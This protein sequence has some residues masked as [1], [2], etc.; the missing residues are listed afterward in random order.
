MAKRSKKS[1]K[2]SIH[3][4]SK[5]DHDEAGAWLYHEAMVRGIDME[6]M[7]RTQAY[8]IIH[9]LKRGER[10]MDVAKEMKLL[11][12]RIVSPSRKQLREMDDLGL[13]SKHCLS[14]Y[15]ASQVLKAHKEPLKVYGAILRQIDKC[16]SEDDLFIAGKELGIVKGSLRADWYEMLV[17]EGK[18]RRSEIEAKKNGEAF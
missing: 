8:G 11:M 17:E 7:S 14:W 10:P 15:H 2:P 12:F 16:V 18:K 1:S 13:P 9:R 6:W 4:G 3:P 5:L